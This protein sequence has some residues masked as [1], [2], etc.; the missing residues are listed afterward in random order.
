MMRKLQELLAPTLI[1]LRRQGKAFQSRLV[2][3]SF[4]VLIFPP[5]DTTLVNPTLF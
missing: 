4:V 5:R 1:T 2:I 3:R